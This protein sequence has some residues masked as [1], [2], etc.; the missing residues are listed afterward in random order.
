[1]VDSPPVAPSSRRGLPFYPIVIAVFPVL[2][3]LSANLSM[4][5]LQDVVR[6][7]AVAFG[8]GVVTV[9]LAS[10]LWRSWER[11]AA[12]AAML[13]AG[14][15]LYSGTV[16]LVG[17]ALNPFGFAPW[18]FWLI[19][20]IL[21]AIAGWKPPRG[22]W[23]NVVAA[24]V[25]AVSGGNLA[26]SVMRPPQVV[27]PKD[28][29]PLLP[30]GPRPDIFHLILDGFGRPDILKDRIGVDLSDFVSELELQGFTVAKAARSNYVQT[31]LSVASSLNYQLIPTLLPE[32]DPN[33]TD[34]RILDSFT[35]RPAIAR[36]LRANGYQTLSILTGFGGLPPGPDT[37]PL[38]MTASMT[39]FEATLL[40]KTPWALRDNLAESMFEVH[41][42]RIRG[43]FTR[44]RELAPRTAR[45]RYVFAHILSPH[46]PFVFGPNG[47]PVR[48]P[49][50]FGVWDGSD[51]LERVGSEE[52]YRRG[53][54]GQVKTL[55][56]WVLEWV[57][58]VRRVQRDRPPLIIVQGDHGSKLGLN[59]DD[60]HRTDLTEAFSILYAVAVPPDVQ[61]KIPA[62]ATPVDT[63]RR[64]LTALGATDVPPLNPGNWYSPYSRP[65]QF[66]EVTVPLASEAGRSSRHRSNGNPATRGA[67]PLAR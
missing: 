35:A 62:D 55:T 17:P 37:L 64:V 14:I 41:R 46:P 25:L 65:F 13:L 57:A 29:A 3:T 10:L 34:R 11:G 45:P 16:H 24:M 19:L 39:V 47:E 61:L 33:L 56:R 21:S 67:G 30:P 1:M 31:E 66:T 22:A 38:P 52:D 5:P 8:A 15:W 50:G 60:V 32:V 54:A 58:T 9:A 53:Y 44:L 7:L 23:P 40:E 63:Y 27:G 51:F 20:V 2:A 18:G 42:A 6:P 4:V 36:R 12:S 43:A 26:Y 59:H 28:Q 48:P 49:G